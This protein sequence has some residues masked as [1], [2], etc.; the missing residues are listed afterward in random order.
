MNGKKISTIPDYRVRGREQLDL[1]VSQKIY[2][3]KIQIIL[4]VNNLSNSG[5]IIYQDLNGNKKFDG[6]LTLRNSQEGKGG[7]YQSGTDNTVVN[8]KPQRTFYF[9]ISYLF[10]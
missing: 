6:P 7:Y 2:K 10:K 9:T 1:Q 4:G 8:I 3:G 5:Q